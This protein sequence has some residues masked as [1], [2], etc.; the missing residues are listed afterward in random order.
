[1]RE[2]SADA[3]CVIGRV[4]FCAEASSA[5]SRARARAREYLSAQADVPDERESELKMCFPRARY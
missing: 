1:M 2:R 5:H 4:R 3:L